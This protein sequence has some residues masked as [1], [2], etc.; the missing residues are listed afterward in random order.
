MPQGLNCSDLWKAAKGA[1]AA[2]AAAAARDGRDGCGGEIPALS[3]DGCALV[4]GA[5]PGA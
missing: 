2:A 1:A 3:D 4:G 5:C